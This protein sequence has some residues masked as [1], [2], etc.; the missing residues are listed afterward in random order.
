[1]LGYATLTGR[2]KREPDTSEIPE[3][4]LIYREFLKKKFLGAKRQKTL[5]ALIKRNL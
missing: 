4:A 5:A 3:K 1:V 2:A